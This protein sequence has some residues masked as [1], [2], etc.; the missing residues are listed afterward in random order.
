MS[1][2]F[3]GQ[4][5]KKVSGKDNVGVTVTIIKLDPDCILGFTLLI[6]SDSPMH[7]TRALTGYRSLSSEGWGR[8]ENWEPIIDRHQ[9]CESE[10]KESLNK[11]LEAANV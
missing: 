9:P 11:L 4:R 5:V 6:L 2:L 8:P 1:R 7:V 10:F 3:I